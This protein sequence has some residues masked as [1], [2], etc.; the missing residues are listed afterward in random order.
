V[1]F[2]FDGEGIRGL[3]QGPQTKS[4]WVQIARS[5]KMVMQFL[6]K[7]RSVAKVV[8][9]DDFKLEQAMGRLEGTQYF[10]GRN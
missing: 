2:V 3:E 8:R 6:S 5:G 9:G 1:D 4:R 10:R 7:G